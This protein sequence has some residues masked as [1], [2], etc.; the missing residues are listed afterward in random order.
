MKNFEDKIKEIKYW[1]GSKGVANWKPRNKQ[2]RKELYDM[3]PKDKMWLVVGS[4]VLEK[5]YNPVY[6]KEFITIYTKESWNRRENY[7][8]EKWGK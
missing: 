3:F 2:L 8:K 5:T 4:Y 6:K 7:M 1:E